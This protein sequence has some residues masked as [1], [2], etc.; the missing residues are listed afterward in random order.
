MLLSQHAVYVLCSSDSCHLPPNP[1]LRLFWIQQSS[2]HPPSSQHF[3]TSSLTETACSL[4]VSQGELATQSPHIPQ[5]HVEGRVFPALHGLFQPSLPIAFSEVH[6]VP[7][8]I[9]FDPPGH[10]FS[11]TQDLAPARLTACLSTRNTP[12]HHQGNTHS[13]VSRGARTAS[14]TLSLLSPCCQVAFLLSASYPPQAGAL[15]P[16]CISRASHPGELG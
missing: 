9:I 1:F 15:K 3:S 4:G 8:T 14:W 16:H 10:A 13:C 12:H 11:L 6:F 5:V 7:V 2:L